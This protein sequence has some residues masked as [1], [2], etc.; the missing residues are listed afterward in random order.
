MTV[1]VQ[2][3][4]MTPIVPSKKDPV[5]I[6]ADQDQGGKGILIGIDGTDGIVKMNPSL[7]IKILR[8]DSLAKL[9]SSD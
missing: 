4:H 1:S 2:M 6:I 9:A 3:N 7:D 8:L 5:V